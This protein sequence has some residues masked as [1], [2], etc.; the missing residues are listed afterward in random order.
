MKY[1]LQPVSPYTGKYL[2]LVKS[3]MGSDR[4]DIV[5]LGV[6]NELSTDQ[7]L[8]Y[9]PKKAIKF[10]HFNL[11]VTVNVSVRHSQYERRYIVRLHSFYF[12]FHIYEDTQ[13][14]RVE[15]ISWP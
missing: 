15:S 9:G 13:L 2:T 8:S 14:I 1:K 10:S 3:H 11:S 7:S 6:V 5:F 4:F 12:K